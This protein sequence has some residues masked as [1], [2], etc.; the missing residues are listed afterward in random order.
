[1]KKFLKNKED[2]VC[3]NCGTEVKGT[4]FTNHCPN[5]FYSKHVDINPGDRNCKCGGLMAPVAI[6][7]KKGDFFIQHKCV[8]CGLI[9]KNSISSND[10]INNLF[11]LAKSITKNEV[12]KLHDKGML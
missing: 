2:F 1:M 4:G 3:E 11:E 7:Q 12:A 8:K 5:C 6:L 9:K 10:N